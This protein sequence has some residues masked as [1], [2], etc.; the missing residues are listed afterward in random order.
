M[1]QNRAIFNFF[2][3]LNSRRKMST[4]FA[5]IATA[6]NRY[7]LNAVTKPECNLRALFVQRPLFIALC[8]LPYQVYQYL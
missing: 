3:V 1:H 2:H 7:D 5:R 6:V 4:L 8:R